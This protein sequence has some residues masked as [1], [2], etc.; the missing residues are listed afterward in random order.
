VQV[1]LLIAEVHGRV[2]ICVNRSYPQLGGRCMAID[3]PLQ[4]SCRPPSLNSLLNK[5]RVGGEPNLSCC[6]APWHATTA[7]SEREKLST[8]WLPGCLATT[9][10]TATH[11]P[12]HLLPPLW[13]CTDNYLLPYT[14]CTLSATSVCMLCQTCMFLMYMCSWPSAYLFTPQLPN[15]DQNYDQQMYVT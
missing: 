8:I 6:Q 2:H 4:L 3:H 11:G 1:L 10:Q 13:Q 7:C 5:G 15:F 14:L 9:T 12:C